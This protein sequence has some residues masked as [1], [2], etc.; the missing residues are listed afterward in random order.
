MQWGYLLSSATATKE[1]Y[2]FLL[3]IS[4]KRCWSLGK[5]NIL[6]GTLKK[7][8]LH[9]FQRCK[10]CAGLQRESVCIGPVSFRIK[11]GTCWHA[12]EW[13]HAWHLVNRVE[14]KPQNKH[15]STKAAL[16]SKIST[17]CTARG[18]FP[19]FCLLAVLLHLFFLQITAVWV[20]LRQ[21]KSCLHG[22]AGAVG[23]C[24]IHPEPHSSTPN[25]AQSLEMEEVSVFVH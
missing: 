3:F 16:P 2:T 25:P 10:R 24:G 17:F 15:T 13:A 19:V 14:K 9:H 5:Q 1:T 12:P 20:W 4:H 18:T 7:M 22:G 11:T 8:S 21:R 6:K 23:R